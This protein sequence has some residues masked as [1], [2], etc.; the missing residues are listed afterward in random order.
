MIKSTI[1][2]YIFTQLSVIRTLTHLTL[3]DP[4]QSRLHITLTLN[5]EDDDKYQVRSFILLCSS[6]FVIHRH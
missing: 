3:C 4:Q 1:F 2:I 6:H 5:D